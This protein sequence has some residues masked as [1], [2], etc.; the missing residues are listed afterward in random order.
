MME[1]V[2]S[3]LATKFDGTV[4]AAGVTFVFGLIALVTGALF[5]AHLNRRRDDRLRSE[6]SK[7]VSAAL[8]GEIL[9]MRQS[10]QRA[11]LVVA[12]KFFASGR[13]NVFNEHTLELTTLRDPRLYPA[14]ASKL[15]LLPPDL[16]LAITKFHADYE[17]VREW[18]PKLVEKPERGYNYGHLF[19]LHPAKNAVFDIKP[20]L[21][22]IERVLNIAD[23]A[24]DP[25]MKVPLEL[26]DILE[27]EQ[28]RG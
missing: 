13:A 16:V 2:I 24:E 26:I 27:E 5:N 21:R 18:L 17:A 19:V 6:E 1:K 11:A 28:E 12:N 14:L 4:S 8:Y 15:G 9:L 25:D 23:P 7:A 22:K 3:L 20:A 10:V